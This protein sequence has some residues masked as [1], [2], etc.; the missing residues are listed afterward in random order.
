MLGIMNEFAVK[1]SVQF[2]STF[3]Y[4]G[5]D[6]DNQRR[7]IIELPGGQRVKEYAAGDTVQ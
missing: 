3:V 6:I 1:H 2:L 7:Q 5:E 4:V